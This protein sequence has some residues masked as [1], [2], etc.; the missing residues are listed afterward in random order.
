M[1]E[2]ATKLKELA[3]AYSYHIFI[4]IA[5]I[6]IYLVTMFPG[7][8][9]R[10]NYGDSI[11]WQYLHIPNG[12]PHGPGYPQFLIL[13][14]IFARLVFFLDMPERIT[15]ISVFF[16]ALSLVV[17][18][19]LLFL[20]TKDKIGSL[21]STF[22]TGFTY[23]FW[24]QATEAE[25]YTLNIFY[26]LSVLYLF[27]QFYITKNSKYYL[28][29][30]AV[31]AL[32][33]GNH[34]S[35]ITI[36]PAIA[37]ISLVTDYRV[38][39][40]LKNLAFITLFVFIGMLQYGLVFY[41][42][43]TSDP[44]YME[45]GPD[46]PFSQLLTYI[47]GSDKTIMFAYTFD[48]ILF[49]R[50]PILLNFVNEN[51]TIL[52]FMFAFAGFFYYLYVKNQYIILTFFSLAL[53]GQL[54]FNISY[55]VG[56]IIVFFIPVYI[57]I[58]VFIG[59]IFSARRDLIL[60]VIL[61]ILI[62]YLVIYNVSTKNVII[63]N[64]YGHVFFRPILS[65]Y[66]EQKDNLPIYF[67]NDN[68]YMEQYI[69]YSNLSGALFPKSIA[70]QLEY[71]KSDSFYVA[72]NDITYFPEVTENYDVKVVKKESLFDFINKHNKPEN[73]IF[74]SAKDEA[75]VNL[76]RDFVDYFKTFGSQI[77]ALPF[78]GSYA[79]VFY[80]GKLLEII[81]GAGVSYIKSKDLTN[82][83]VE[84]K[85]VYEVLSAGNPFGNDSQIKVNGFDYSVKIR[86]INIVVYNIKENKMTEM[87]G[88]DT[89]IGA[90]VKLFIATKKPPKID[91][92]ELANLYVLKQKNEESIKDFV[93]NRDKPSQVI[94]L[95]AKDEASQNLPQ[96]LKDYLKQYGSKIASLPYRGSYGA[97]F[98]NGKL[99]EEIN[100]EGP[101]AIT[102][103]SLKD[104]LLGGKLKY[105][106]FSSGQ[107]YGD[108]S[109]IKLNNFD[110]S[111]RGRGL[112][113]V[114]FDTEINQVTDIVYYD[115]H[116]G[117]ENKSFRAVKK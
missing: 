44:L 29:G 19:S 60:K 105:E 57:L 53:T 46:P 55:A 68:Y 34:L 30:C 100:G 73:V 17:F 109:S 104:D 43:Y 6:T 92:P 14:E 33:F 51:Y 102:S 93:Q 26:L 90:E 7:E 49:E 99:K 5:F 50:F 84:G 9:G 59:L 112:N 65:L 78:R 31:Y 21:I 85:L 42:A 28:W 106:I 52:G 95:S 27:I 87:L 117:E 1:K 45:I 98:Y 2:L 94:F 25:V 20:L 18:Y 40:K 101:I 11:K 38:V 113:I 37:F 80:Q 67:R 69:N 86:G 81:N 97:V 54:I 79:A 111:I 4:F 103:D 22:L 8:G 32:S 48:R 116:L 47:T 66:Q 75:T 108:N 64:T 10:I 16:G 70:P 12:L 110:Y 3:L 107:P 23:V 96:N 62:V 72:A 58:G 115:T 61:S 36:L 74:L 77:E 114:V 82:D 89:H 39:F 76:P 35:M 63:K 91:N 41:R 15:F 83:P 13:T 56:D 24:T 88:Y 71:I